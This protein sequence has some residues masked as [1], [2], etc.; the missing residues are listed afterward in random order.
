MGS[1]FMTPALRASGI[2]AGRAINEPV[3][4]A[5]GQGVSAAKY[6][7]AAG[8]LNQKPPKIPKHGPGYPKVKG[9]F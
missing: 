8:A 7:A 6:I 1:G 9:G 2:T 3:Y 4:N 5:R